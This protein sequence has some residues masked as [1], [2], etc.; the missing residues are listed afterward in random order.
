MERV[1][2]FNRNDMIVNKAT[3]FL[4]FIISSLAVKNKVVY[5]F[6]IITSSFS[7]RKIYPS[8]K[9]TP[10]MMYVHAYHYREL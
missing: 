1:I 3:T 5:I 10:F 2:E 8:R 6:Y 9:I 7:A 4:C